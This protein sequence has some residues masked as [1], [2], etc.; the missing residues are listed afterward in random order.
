MID[1]YMHYGF[2]KLT[3]PWLVRK[4]SPLNEKEFLQSPEDRKK[5]DGLYECILCG[6][7]NASCPPFWWS[8]S[9]WTGP[10][11][12]LLS[13]RWIMD[14]RN[15]NKEERIKFLIEKKQLSICDNVGSCTTACPV[16]LDPAKAVANMQDMAEEYSNAKIDIWK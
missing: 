8:R 1:F 13:Y 11:L 14:S 15:E 9:F 3:K 6:I 16:G 4:S 10:N 7:C 12:L 5:L 2:Y